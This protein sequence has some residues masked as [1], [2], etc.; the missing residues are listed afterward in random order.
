MS[1]LLNP[2]IS[3]PHQPFKITWKLS[4]GQ[5]HDT[6]NETS[7]I[8]PLNTWWPDLYFDLRHIFGETRQSGHSKRS[9]AG[10]GRGHQSPSITDSGLARAT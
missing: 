10:V 1:G 2:G 6:L 9:P 5:V 8:H 3:N 4:D 7:G